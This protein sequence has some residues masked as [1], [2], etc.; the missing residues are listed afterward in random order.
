M[1]VIVT[2]GPTREY[3]D[4][5]RFLSNA[6]SGRMGYAVAWEAVRRGHGTVLVSGPVCLEAP[7]GVVF[8]PVVSAADMKD[9]VFRHAAGA[10]AIVMAA[11][12]SDWRPA[13]KIEGKPRREEGART[14]ELVPTEDVL[15]EVLSSHDHLLGVA[16]AME[17]EMDESAAVEKMKRKG[18]SYVVLN[19]VESMGN[20]TVAYKMIRHDGCV[21]SE[22]NG[23]KGVL[24]SV[25]LDVLEGELG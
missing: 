24:A 8:E 15:R 3:I 10:D 19:T 23:G 6:S 13:T 7:E 25:I 22:G 4:A 21:V 18:A 14:L 5:V 1:K 17:M 20:D 11:A 2:A 16:F 12:V 9:A